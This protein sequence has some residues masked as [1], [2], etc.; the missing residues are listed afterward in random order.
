GDYALAFGNGMIFGGGIQS[1]RTLAAVISG[2]QRSFGMRGTIS[3]SPNSLQG[4]AVEIGAGPANIMM[5]ASN[6]P[7]DAMVDNDS[8]QTLYPTDYHQTQAELAYEDAASSSVVG[9]RVEIATN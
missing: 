5:F 4:G 1:S 8:I 2:E 3:N 6:R 7:V 9:A